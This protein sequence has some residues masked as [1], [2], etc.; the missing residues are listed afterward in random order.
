V[1]AVRFLPA[2]QEKRAALAALAAGPALKAMLRF[3]HPF[4][5]QLAHGRYRR[6]GFF[7]APQAAFPTFWT[8]YPERAPVLVAWAGGPRARRLAR[9][10]PAAVV[11]HALDSARELFGA[12][13]DVERE[14]VA[15]YLHDW[16]R[17]PNARGAYSYVQV[18]GMAARKA[19]AQP[20]RATHY[21]A[22]EAADYEGEAGTVAGA[23]QSGVRA[24][25]RLLASHRAARA[26]A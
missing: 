4:W 2:L 6:A 7:Q 18:G 1:D 14:L 16:Q 3:R 22:G 15:A 24:A 26:S 8:A 17:D 5:M 23:L 12:G 11:R 20:L 13:V 10:D 19:L 25:R 9:A 21:F